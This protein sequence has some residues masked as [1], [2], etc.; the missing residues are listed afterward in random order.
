MTRV[1]TENKVMATANLRSS[2]KRMSLFQ[3]G[4]LLHYNED[5]SKLIEYVKP[6]SLHQYLETLFGKVAMEE[7]MQ[8]CGDF[9]GSIVFFNCFIPPSNKL[10]ICGHS[11]KESKLDEE[12]L[13]QQLSMSFQ[14]GA[15]EWYNFTK[16]QKGTMS[17]LMPELVGDILRRLPI[18]SVLASICV[19]R[20]W[21][22]AVGYLEI[23]DVSRV[24]LLATAGQQFKIVVWFWDGTIHT[25][26][27]GQTQ[28]C[29]HM[30]A[31]SPLSPVLIQN[32]LACIDALYREFVQ[33]DVASNTITIKDLNPFP[34]EVQSICL[35]SWRGKLYMEVCVE[36]GDPIAVVSTHVVQELHHFTFDGQADNYLNVCGYNKSLKNGIDSRK[37]DFLWWDLQED[38]ILKA[39]CISGCSHRQMGIQGD[40]GIVFLDFG[41]DLPAL[42]K[43]LLACN[44]YGELVEKCVR[45]YAA[46][47]HPEEKCVPLAPLIQSSIWGKSRL[48][49]ELWRA[50]MH[51]LYISCLKEKSTGFPRR[52]KHLPDVLES[53]DESDVI[54][55]M[56]SAISVLNRSSKD[57]QA[58]IQLLFDLCTIQEDAQ[59]YAAGNCF[60]SIVIGTDKTVANFI[61]TSYKDDPSLRARPLNSVNKLYDPGRATCW[62]IVKISKDRRRVYTASAAEP[63][64]AVAAAELL[65]CNGDAYL[66]EFISKLI[67]V[68]VDGL[69]LEAVCGGMA[70]RLV[71]LLGMH[72]CTKSQKYIKPVRLQEYLETLFGKVAVEELKQCCGDFSSN[73]VFFN[74][75]IATM[76][77]PS[78]KQYRDYYKRASAIICRKNESILDL[79]IPANQEP[80]QA[81]K[82]E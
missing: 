11:T 37:E 64:L 72:E 70:I 9:L 44:T 39:A 36:S 26:S 41:N 18:S 8:C 28:W 77:M 10:Y 40:T 81:F 48:M 69:V 24:F 79:I 76:S 57:C 51:F 5:I 52:T 34:A 75:F 30:V 21:K 55:L 53:W 1:E 3:G 56:A 4:E 27:R 74:C 49:C 71:M 32:K 13:D 68:C 59:V 78:V 54:V 62:T 19:C 25:F 20:A 73:M 16:V 67:E 17:G 63:A 15:T 2:L 33:F 29:Q 61:A 82:F 43:S 22:A 66:C 12:R 6:V 60:F 47:W 38:Q 45:R 58:W 35:A 80:R 14:A 7:L 50:G 42:V 65:H 46:C 31:M 23:W